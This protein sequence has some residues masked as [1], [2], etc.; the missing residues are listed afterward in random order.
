MSLLSFK[1]AYA[2]LSPI[3]KSLLN[4]LASLSDIW[5]DAVLRPEGTGPDREVRVT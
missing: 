2:P 3:V 5:H 1:G 4:D